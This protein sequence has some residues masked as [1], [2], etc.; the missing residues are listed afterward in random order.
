MKIGFLV[1]GF[2][3]TAGCVTAQ[4]TLVPQSDK[5]KVHF[6]IK[7]LG[8][9][10]GG[11]LSNLEGKIVINEKN[12]NKSYA[13][14]T[15]KVETIDTDNERRDKH[16]RSADYF[17]IEKYPTIRIVSTSISKDDKSGYLFN[18]NIIIKGITKTISFPFAVLKNAE[19]FLLT[20]NFSI[21]RLDFGVGGNSATMS[22][23]VKVEL[24]IF[25]K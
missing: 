18:G 14:V 20:G 1:L 21:N 2:L 5:S 9:N 12:I 22:D 7:N 24:S 16:L 19:G 15:V 3:L 13:D 23:T 11:D 4:K 8:I 17:D 6:I 10:T 25:A